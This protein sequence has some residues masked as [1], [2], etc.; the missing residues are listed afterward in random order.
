VAEKNGRN[1][2]NSD[3]RSRQRASCVGVTTEGVV[4][5]QFVASPDGGGPVFCSA[6]RLA[7][8]RERIHS[9]TRSTA[10]RST[11]VVTSGG[12]WAVPRRE[13]RW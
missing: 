4:V 6:Q 12:I 11:S 9:A 5:S 13:I 7:A 3:C 10:T 1:R 2:G 8:G